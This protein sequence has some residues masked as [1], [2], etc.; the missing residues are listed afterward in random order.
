[1]MILKI[2]AA[3]LLLTLADASIQPESCTALLGRP[4][5][6]SININLLSAED[7]YV[8]AEY[9]VENETALNPATASIKAGEPQNMVISDLKP[10]MGYVYRLCYGKAED[11]IIQCS[12]EYF[13]HT[14]RKPGSS[15]IFDIQADSHLDDRTDKDLYCQTLENELSD[16]PDFL[17]DLGDTFMTE[18]A[19]T[20]KLRSYPGAISAAALFH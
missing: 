4:T 2:L 1:M 20:E 9:R 6:Q 12:P 5:D 8:F 17:I 10:D 3:A 15:F 7:L 18:K 11:A 14:Q 16:G 13:F 19:A